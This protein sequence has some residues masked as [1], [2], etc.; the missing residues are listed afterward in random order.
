MLFLS[1]EECWSLTNL[2]AIRN[3]GSLM[4]LEAVDRTISSTEDPIHLRDLSEDSQVWI[5][6][7][8]VE[9]RFNSTTES[10]PRSWHSNLNLV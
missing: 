10:F 3:A 9:M 6:Q 5:Q 1:S 4:V 8:R 7:F 2:S